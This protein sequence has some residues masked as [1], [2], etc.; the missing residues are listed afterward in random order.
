MDFCPEEAGSVDPA[1]IFKDLV[2]CKA[3]LDKLKDYQATI[4]ASQKLGR[5]PLAAFELN[6]LFVGSPGTGKHVDHD[7]LVPQLVAGKSEKANLEPCF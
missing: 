1:A 2:G 4:T 6:F 7:W 3:V 5:D